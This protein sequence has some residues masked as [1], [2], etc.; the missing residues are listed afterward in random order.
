MEIETEDRSTHIQKGKELTGKC[1]EAGGTRSKST[2][3]E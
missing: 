2:E 3:R 1:R